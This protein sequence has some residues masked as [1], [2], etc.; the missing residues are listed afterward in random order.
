LGVGPTGS[1]RGPR[2]GCFYSNCQYAMGSRVIVGDPISEGPRLDTHK[3]AQGERDVPGL[4]V[5]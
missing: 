2:S 1:G 5:E 3:A 4:D